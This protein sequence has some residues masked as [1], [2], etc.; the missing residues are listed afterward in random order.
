MKL[1]ELSTVRIVCYTRLSMK[2]SEL[3]TVRIVCYTR[4]SMKLSEALDSTN[5]MLYQV[6]NET[7]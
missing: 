2:L 4:L 5:C 6:I 7:E 1:S 3:S